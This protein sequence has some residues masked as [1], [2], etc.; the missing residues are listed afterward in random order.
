MARSGLR[1]PDD[2]GIPKICTGLSMFD[3]DP[4]QPSI[5]EIPGL[6]SLEECTVLIDKIETLGPVIAPINGL[7]GFEVRTDVRNNERVMFDDVAFASTLLQRISEHAAREVHGKSLVGVNERFRCYR[8]QPG[9]RFAR[10]RDGAFMRSASEISCYSFLIYLNESFE[11]G[12]TTF[13]SDYFSDPIGAIKPKT[14]HGL[15]FQ[16]RLLH[17]GSIVNSGTKYVFRSDLMYRS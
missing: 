10:H 7:S 16:H 17:E 6:L 15:L 13:F 3:I 12:E 9:M 2:S 5:I 1:R 11:G 8:Y 14:G 4:N